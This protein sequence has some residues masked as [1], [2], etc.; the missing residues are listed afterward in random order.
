MIFQILSSDSATSLIAVEAS[1]Y[2]TE[3]ADSN[4]DAAPI[5]P[6]QFEPNI[7]L[8]DNSSEESGKEGEEND[9]RLFNLAGW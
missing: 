9:E 1:N 6:Y 5:V 7:E 4:D 3:M 2:T 8:L